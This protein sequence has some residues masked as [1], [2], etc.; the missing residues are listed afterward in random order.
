ML[1]DPGENVTV[2]IDDPLTGK[3]GYKLLWLV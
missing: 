1:E 2:D 3:H